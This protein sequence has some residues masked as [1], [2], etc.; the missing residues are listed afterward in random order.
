M[1]M[2]SLGALSK[3]GVVTHWL[4]IERAVVFGVGEITPR[5][6]QADIRGRQQG[7]DCLKYTP[8]CPTR[9]L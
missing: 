6:K 2:F 7:R 1:G 8:T 9:A 5:C 4:G 3:V